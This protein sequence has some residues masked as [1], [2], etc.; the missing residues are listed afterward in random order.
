MVQHVEAWKTW[1]SKWN[2]TGRN[3]AR[4]RRGSGARCE[5]VVE[6]I[7]QSMVIRV[8]KKNTKESGEFMVSDWLACTS[9][10]VNILYFLVRN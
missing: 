2:R 4:I 3:N 7:L 9:N 6:G 5:E 8:D 1:C 10:S